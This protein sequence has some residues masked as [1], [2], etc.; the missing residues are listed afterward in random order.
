MSTWTYTEGD[1]PLPT[2]IGALAMHEVRA[3]NAVVALDLA[4]VIARIAPQAV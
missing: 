1:Y 4:A 3:V 2:P